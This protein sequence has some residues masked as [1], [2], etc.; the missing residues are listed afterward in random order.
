VARTACLILAVVGFAW[1]GWL[2]LVGG[3][4]TEILGLRVRSNAPLRPLIGGAIAFTLFVFLGGRVPLAWVA[5]LARVRPTERVQVIAL[6]LAVTVFGI[7]WAATVA[8]GSDS[9][10]YVSQADLWLEGDLRIEQPWVEEAT[11]PSRRWSFAPLGYRSLNDAFVI[12]PTYAP[13]LPL[14]MAGAKAIGGQEGLFWVVPL[15]GGLL[16]FATY[17]VARRVAPP[18]AALIAAWLMASC[19]T[20]LYMLVSPMSDVAVAGLWMAACLCILR[21]GVG[22]AAAGGVCAALAILVRPNLVF[23]AAILLV[24]PLWRAV[25][26]REGRSLAAWQVVAFSVCAAIGPVAVALINQ[27]LYGSASESGY[28]DISV[29]F[30]R[31]H[32]WPNLVKYTTWL[33]ETQTAAAAAG[34]AA[35]FL[36]WRRLW[37]EPD[38]RRFLVISASVVA[39]VWLFYCL[40]YE[41]DAWWFLRFMLPALPFIAIGVATVAVAIRNAG[42]RTTRTVVSLV[43]LMIVVLQLRFVVDSH[44]LTF[45]RGDR[46]YVSVGRLVG[47]WTPEH[48]VIISNQ[49]SGSIR[50]YGGR[51]TLR[52]DNIDG[53]SIDEAIAWFSSRGVPTYLLVEEWE[54][55][56]FQAR[57][58]GE[59]VLARLDTPIV[60]YRGPVNAM[61]YDMVV[62]AGG[63]PREVI[64]TGEHLR[65]VPP[66]PPVRFSLPPSR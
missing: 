44:V 16:V 40:Y 50:Y 57:A 11:W 42:G 52:F 43:L 36:P 22:S 60:V 14:L 63:T 24:W 39:S 38:H 18:G 37:P 19:P 2:L 20:M 46:R 33:L 66:V 55:P 23:L 7:G 41:Y 6:S 1:G 17:G 49:H 29:M 9:Y 47:Q 64:D 48:S 27:Y 34:L 65:S 13:G 15:L 25:R 21:P 54:L 61:L 51:M 45:W 31:S 3:F 62:P 32:L 56:L 58:A 12:V 59:A 5:V 53:E 8:S 28:G 4:D 26:L 10:G 35:L 30:D